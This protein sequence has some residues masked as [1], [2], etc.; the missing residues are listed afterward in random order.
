[1]GFAA[2]LGT[3]LAPFAAAAAAARGAVAAYIA[4][5]WLP[6]LIRIAPVAV[7]ALVF[8]LEYGL[9]D[10]AEKWKVGALAVSAAVAS[11]DVA[12][13]LPSIRP[14]SK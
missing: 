12:G 5:N 2:I 10:V 9:G 4:A 1:M 14:A 3:L 7:F 8:G 11:L 13:L 6:F